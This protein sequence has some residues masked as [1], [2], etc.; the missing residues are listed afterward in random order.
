[1]N[2]YH[3]TDIFSADNIL[4][5]GIDLSASRRGLDF[6]AGFYVTPRLAQAR[7]WAEGTIAPCVLSMGLDETGLVI[8]GFDSPNQELAEFVVRNRLR[9]PIKHNYDWA[10]GPMADYGVSHLYTRYL[11]HKVT[12]E[13]AVKQ[14]RQDPNG[15]QWVVLTQRAIQNLKNIRKV[16][17]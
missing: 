4:H 9:L 2:L 13:Q 16:E 10:Y 1:M 6:G 3:G 15:W 5:N 17:L 11:A 14:I 12:F 8:K 7:V